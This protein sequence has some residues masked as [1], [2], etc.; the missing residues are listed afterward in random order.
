[1]TSFANEPHALLPS[2][3]REQVRFATMQELRAALAEATPRSQEP[4]LAI[5]VCI[6]FFI[7]LVVLQM[8][9]ASLLVM[10]FLPSAGWEALTPA[11][12]VAILLVQIA[13]GSTLSTRPISWSRST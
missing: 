6:G 5:M 10:L 3:V 1:M 9:M 11:L 4:L 12:A 13:A 7:G 8:P 2:F